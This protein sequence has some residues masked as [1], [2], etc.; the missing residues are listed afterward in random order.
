MLVEFKGRGRYY[1][2]KVFKKD[3]VLE[4]DDVECIMIEK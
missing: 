3:V 1:V 2:I 4:D